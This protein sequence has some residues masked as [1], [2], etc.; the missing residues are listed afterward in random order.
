MVGVGI[1][2]KY[3]ILIESGETREQIALK[4]C[5]C[6]CL[7]VLKARLDVVLSSVI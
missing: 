5:G 6:P 4:S 3:F 2:K 1:R 7:E